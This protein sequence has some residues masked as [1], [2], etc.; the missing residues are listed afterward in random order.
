MG[1]Q[2]TRFAIA[3]AFFKANFEIFFKLVFSN[4]AK[5]KKFQIEDSENTILMDKVFG[6]SINQNNA[7]DLMKI[8]AI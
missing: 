4:K 6:K 3:P 5:Q 8:P 7:R 1:E 2:H